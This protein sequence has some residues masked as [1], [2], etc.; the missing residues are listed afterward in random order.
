MLQLL[1]WALSG[2][3]WSGVVAMLYHALS[4]HRAVNTTILRQENDK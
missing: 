2:G 1:E 4:Y 3:L